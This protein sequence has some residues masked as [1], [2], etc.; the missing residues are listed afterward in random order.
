MTGERQADAVKHDDMTGKRKKGLLLY[1][2]FPADSFWS[3]RYIMN[4]VNRKAAFPPLGLL[5]FAA[6]MTET[7]DFE[8]LDFNVHK[9]EISYLI[10]KINES[11]A[12]FVSAMSIQKPSLVTLLEATSGSTRAPWVLGG[13]LASTYRDQIMN[14][15]A[16]SDKVLHDGLDIVVWGEAAEW[17]EAVQN[18]LEAHP[19]HSSSEP[20]L[21]IPP[22]VMET[23]PGAQKYLLDRNIFKPLEGVPIPRW[24]LI[25]IKDYWSMMIQTTAGCPFRCKFCDIIMFNGGFSRPKN[26]INVVRELEEIYALGHRGSVFTVDDNFIGNIAAISEIL[27]DIIEF[28]RRHDYPFDLFTQASVDI[29]KPQNE[30]IIEKMQKAGFSAVFMGIENP[31]PEALKAMNKKQNNLVD[32]KETVK[33]IQQYGIE[34]FAG[35]IFGSDE[36]TKESADGIIEFVKQTDIV[37]AMTGMLT[38][39]PHTVLY[40]ELEREGRL[41]KSEFVANNID[42][43][44][45]F[46]PKR[47]TMDEMREG[48]KRITKTLFHHSEAFRRSLSMLRNTP[49]HIFS[50]KR[51][52][53]SYLKAAALSMWR[54][55]IKRVDSNYFSFL[56]RAISLDS[57]SIRR[58]KGEFRELRRIWLPVLRSNVS[59]IRL[60]EDMCG[61]LEKLLDILPDAIIRYKTNIARDAAGEICK[62]MRKSLADRVMKREELLFAYEAV[63]LYYDRR[64]RQYSFPGYYLKRFFELAVKTLHY[65]TVVET[66]FSGK[67]RN[68]LD[69]AASMVR[70]ARAERPATKEA[71][72]SISVAILEHSY[73][74]QIKM[75]LEVFLKELGV[76]VVPAREYINSKLEDGQKLLKQGDETVRHALHEYIYSLQGKT[77]F[78]IVPI[79]RDLNQ[80]QERF[81]T[82]YEYLASKIKSGA[83]ALPMLIDIDLDKEYALLRASFTKIGLLFNEDIEKVRMAYCKAFE[84]AV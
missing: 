83:A 61:S 37:T 35:F 69:R 31:N 29:G 48:I 67:R 36:D 63:S 15:E 28:Q 34:V 56:R 57:E 81:V 21:F 25:D 73:P 14:P 7:W 44:I 38:P 65:E 23:K 18:E 16:Y 71:D 58:A 33:R 40:D 60:S 72:G 68:A 76:R 13:P 8:L 78:I 20:R 22:Q 59:E 77:D 74:G 62:G 64:S 43:E 41:M 84:F 3:Y 82:E 2:E 53:W 70:S 51:F 5:T 52:E 9:Y 26:R 4:F 42:D 54:Q 49:P 1:P 47:M 6:Y 32:L 19:V 30:H 45:Q 50:S 46:I 17:I 11:D 79:R 12:V 55:G 39:L 24:D 80:F 27:D 75:R 66:L 10:E